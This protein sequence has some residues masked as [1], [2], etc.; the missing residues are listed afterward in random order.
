LSHAV[1]AYLDTVIFIFLITPRILNASQSSRPLCSSPADPHYRLTLVSG[2][3][4]NGSAGYSPK[5]IVSKLSLFPFIVW[6]TWTCA[7]GLDFSMWIAHFLALQSAGRFSFCNSSFVVRS[8]PILVLS[9]T[10]AVNLGHRLQC[11]LWHS[12]SLSG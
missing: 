11:C 8:L 3:L 7:V 9:D 10:D 5:H 12:G 4:C 6:Q 2:L 1:S